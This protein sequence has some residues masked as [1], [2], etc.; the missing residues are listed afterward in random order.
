[1]NKKKTLMSL[2][3]LVVSLISIFFVHIL[4][5]C[6]SPIDSDSHAV[7]LPAG[8]G[9]FWLALT[10]G[11]RTILP[12]AP[13]LND[14]A[15]YNLTFTPIDSGVPVNVERTN[16]TLNT[17]IVLAPG[18]YSLV[19]TAYKDEGKKQ[20][21]SRGTLDRITINAGTNTPG[22]V[23][24]KPLL[25]GGT[26][27]FRYDINLP[28]VFIANMTIKPGQ[29][30]GTNQETVTLPL[31]KAAGSRT[32]NSGQYTVTIYLEKV[33]G[34]K[35]VWNELLYVYQNLESIFNFTFTDAHFV[36]PMY[37]V[38]F[39]SNGG[40]T[41]IGM[42]SVMPIMHG[43]KVKRPEEDPTSARYKF[44]GWYTNSSGTG[45]PWDFATPVIESFT[46]YAK[47]GATLRYVPVLDEEIGW[48]CSVHDDTYNGH[49]SRLGYI[50]HVP[51]TSTEP[52]YY[53]GVTPFTL[54]YEVS[55]ATEHS[56]M[57]SSTTTVE[58]SVSRNTNTTFTVGFE[59]GYDDGFVAKLNES[60]GISFDIGTSET[61]ST[62]NTYETTFNKVKELT[63]GRS[64]TIG[65]NGEPAGDYRLAMECIVDA[66]YVVLTDRANSK[67]EKAYFTLCARPASYHWVKDY[68]PDM[69]SGFGSNGG[70]NKLQEPIIDLATLPKP[71]EFAVI[72]PA[73]PKASPGAGKYPTNKR[74][75]PISLISTNADVDIYY[76]TDGKKP[77]QYST[78]YDGP[79]ELSSN[80][81]VQA[82]AVTKYFESEVLSA[83]YTFEDEVIYVE[84]LYLY[85]ASGTRAVSDVYLEFINSGVLSFGSKRDL[86]RG[87]PGNHIFLGYKTTTDSAKAI[88]GLYIDV[89]QGSKW[90]DPFSYG[91]VT[92]SIVRNQKSEVIDL[93]KGDAGTTYIWLYRS[94]QENAGSPIKELFIQVVGEDGSPTGDGWSKVNVN[95]NKG[96]AG[97]SMFLWYRR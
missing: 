24:L 32:L 1:M 30:G 20:L 97:V 79:I 8:K 89:D 51:I 57:N 93:N 61:I 82:I 39:D 52:Q 75:M 9:L 46:L 49:V 34:E 22:T 55:E 40:N 27:T 87:A 66:Y 63:I 36:N 78:K 2:R 83:K 18:T 85:N 10:D 94:K 84:E 17:P 54:T 92:Y 12:A 41:S 16:A 68:D 15:V 64:I 53:D 72:S 88:R 80:V 91:G 95:L 58:N 96:N 56:I 13:K 90:K 31:P 25:S 14:F 65:G 67:V 74:G 38:I 71:T 73:K 60:L 28:E 6:D 7:E 44:D 3:I 86:N 77:T 70:G 21:M 45:N 11:S 42:Q 23:I 69:L 19:V 33:N 4:I 35:L 62:S 50:L 48:V 76:T 59:V 26:G 37:T 81:D 43:G 47:W 29:E 5:G